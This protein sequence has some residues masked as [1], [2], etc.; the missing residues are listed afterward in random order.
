MAEEGLAPLM[1]TIPSLHSK[2]SNNHEAIA[3]AQND[4]RPCTGIAWSVHYLQVDV[5]SVAECWAV[6]NQKSRQYFYT[7]VIWYL[8]RASRRAGSKVN[9]S[10]VIFLENCIDTRRKGQKLISVALQ[11]ARSRHILLDTL[12]LA[13]N[14]KNTGEM[15]YKAVQRYSERLTPITRPQYGSA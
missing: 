2:R 11:T 8:C 9:K 12:R 13:M 1:R 15:S 5:P 10:R 7:L 6:Q 4:A 3:S 14:C